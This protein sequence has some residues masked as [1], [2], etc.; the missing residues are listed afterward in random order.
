MGVRPGLW[1]LRAGNSLEVLSQPAV[2]ARHNPPTFICYL[3]KQ[4][5]E[6][7]ALIGTPKGIGVGLCG[8]LCYPELPSTPPTKQVSDVC[9]WSQN[10]RRILLRGYGQK[11]PSS[12]IG[13][14]LPSAGCSKVAVKPARNGPDPTL[15]LHVLPANRHKKESRRATR[16]AFLIIRS[17]LFPIGGVIYSAPPW[18]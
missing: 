9:L 11:N 6:I 10:S 7:R 17:E 13:A 15:C 18:S 8:L 4:A 5:H 14:A 12:E 2:T 16:T 3:L 1:T